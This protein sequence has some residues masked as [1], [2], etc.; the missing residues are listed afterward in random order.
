MLAKAAPR[1]HLQS[2]CC[3]VGYELVC[4][5]YGRKRAT[6]TVFTTAALAATVDASAGDC[7]A[8]VDKAAKTW[9][10]LDDHCSDIVAVVGC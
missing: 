8:T 2:A 7:R 3:G 1:S 4:A 10:G 9:P 5:S 6:T